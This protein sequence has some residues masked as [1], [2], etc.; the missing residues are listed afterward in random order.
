[1]SALSSHLDPFAHD[2]IAGGRLYLSRCM[3]CGLIVAASPDESLLPFAERVHVCPVYLSYNGL[4]L[5]PG[6]H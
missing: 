5:V 3:G 1:M 6:Q 4:S 2:S